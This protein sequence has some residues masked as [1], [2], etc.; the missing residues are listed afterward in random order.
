MFHKHKK[1]LIVSKTDRDAIEFL[2]RSKFAYNNFPDWM[3][4]LW[5]AQMN[6]HRIEFPNGSTITSLPSTPNV[7]RSN[8]SSLNIIDEAAFIQHMDQVWAAGYPTMQHGGSTIIISTPAGVGDWYYE[9]WQAAGKGGIFNPILINWW[10]MDWVL[11]YKDVLTGQNRRIAPCDGLRECTT[12]EE[13]E[14]YG[15]YWSPWL[16]SQYQALKS[17]GEAHKFKQEFLCEFVGGGNTIIPSFVIRHIDKQINSQEITHQLVT[18]PVM[19]IDNMT[20]ER[21]YLD[22]KG[23]DSE[24][25]LWV[26]KEPVVEQRDARG[27][28]LKSGDAYVIGVDIAT[29]VNNDFSA[30]QVMDITTQEQVAEYVGR[31]ETKIFAKMV[32]QIGR[33]YNNALAVI[34]RTGIGGPFVDE[35]MRDLL[36]PNLW[37]RVDKTRAGTSKSTKAGFATSAASKPLLNKVLMDNLSDVEGEGYIIRSYRLLREFQTYVRM[38]TKA[39]VDTQKVGAQFGNHDDLVI[40]CALAFM[41]APDAFDNGGLLPFKNVGNMTLSNPTAKSFDLSKYGDVLMPFVPSSNDG[42]ST[43]QMELDKFTNQLG[44]CPV[45]APAVVKPKNRFFNL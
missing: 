45:V 33:W 41:G 40:A 28:V 38:T 3:K 36:Y 25:G 32:D 13:I 29:G 27:K 35:N 10:D 30:I 14:K 6:E 44:S 2:K 19:H 34:E 43:P 4:Q 18:E 1:V 12:K 26:W 24:T 11:E 39:G 37:Y 9:Q 21:S 23:F 31:V 7:L 15:P 16:E 42:Y 5:K 17:K 22:F 20:G 8:A